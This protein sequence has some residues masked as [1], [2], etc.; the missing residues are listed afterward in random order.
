MTADI[1]TPGHIKSIRWLEKK[2]K[3]LIVGILTDKA[4]VGYKRNVV[5]FEDRFF[6]IKSITKN[7]VPQ[8]YLSP[9]Q[10]IKKYRPDAI[11]SG[12]GWEDEELKV[13]KK[14]KLNIVDID[15]PKEHSSTAIKK[16]VCQNECY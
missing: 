10:N 2:C 13:I 11:A 7:V 14:Y 12:D 5:C 6:I 16:R 15:I 4:L 9:E 1:L 8:K 3:N